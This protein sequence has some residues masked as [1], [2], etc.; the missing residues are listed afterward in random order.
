MCEG[1]MGMNEPEERAK[2]KVHMN[3]PGESSSRCECS[4]TCN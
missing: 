1:E 2:I 3:L 4:I